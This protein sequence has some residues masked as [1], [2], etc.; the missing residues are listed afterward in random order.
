[1]RCSAYE[2]CQSCRE[3]SELFFFLKASSLFPF[4]FF[5]ARLF[6]PQGAASFCV[7]FSAPGHQLLFEQ[8]LSR[9]RPSCL[10]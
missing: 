3:R 5:L 4:R 1:M 7:P 9:A 8:R 2:G 6:D 10:A